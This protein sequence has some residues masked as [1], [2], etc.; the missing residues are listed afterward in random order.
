[1]KN[2]ALTALILIAAASLAPS[3]AAEIAPQQT[4]AE[5]TIEAAPTVR[6]RCFRTRS[7]A[8]SYAIRMINCGYKARYDYDCNRGAWVAT[9]W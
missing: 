1:M 2:T 7:G 8:R 9:W 5:A 6:R 4:S 3:A